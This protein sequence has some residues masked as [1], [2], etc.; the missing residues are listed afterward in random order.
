MDERLC[1]CFSGH[2]G[3][4]TTWNIT[5]FKPIINTCYFRPFLK[6]HFREKVYRCLW[7]MG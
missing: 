4:I 3:Q 2:A 5:R 6:I 7:V 1:Y